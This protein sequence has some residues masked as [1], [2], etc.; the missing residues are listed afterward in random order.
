LAIPGLESFPCVNILF[1]KT[2]I[3]SAF[4]HPVFIENHGNVRPVL[5]EQHVYG[6]M[7]SLAI[8]P[9]QAVSDCI[10]S[11]KRW[12]HQFAGPVLDSAHI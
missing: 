10:S 9:T 8:E 7:V 12:C 6:V 5:P 2:I 11:G 4:V 1:C 3:F